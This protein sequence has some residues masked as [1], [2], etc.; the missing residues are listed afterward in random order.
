VL[1]KKNSR[2]KMI[3]I[4]NNRTKA[5]SIVIMNISRSIKWKVTNLTMKKSKNLM[6][7][8]SKTIEML[9]TRANFKKEKEMEKEL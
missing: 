7:L 8:V 6:I 2:K 1:P 5:S 4:P 9:L 3:I